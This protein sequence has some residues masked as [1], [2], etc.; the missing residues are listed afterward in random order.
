MRALL[1]AAVGLVGACAPGAAAAADWT[2]T[3]TGAPTCKTLADLTVDCGDVLAIW[4]YVPYRV[5]DAEGVTRETGTLRVP[6]G[7]GDQALADS[8][9]YRAHSKR[10][11]PAPAPA[12]GSGTVITVP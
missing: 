9:R 4:K 8:L 6:K 3:V 10:Y 1:C 2:V 7:L 12:V 5:A 11:A